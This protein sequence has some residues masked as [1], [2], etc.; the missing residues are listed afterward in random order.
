MR[1][2][3]AELKVGVSN[4]TSAFCHSVLRLEPYT[5]CYFSCTY[6]YAR[7]Y[8]EQGPPEPK[9][10][11]I[12]ALRKLWPKL[13]ASPELRLVPFRLSTLADPLQPAEAKEKL[14][15][16]ILRL[17][18]EFDVPVVLNTKSV[19][20]TRG[21]WLSA[22]EELASEGLV[23]LQVSISALSPA[24]SYTHLTLPTTERV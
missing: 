18:G 1:V 21:P 4:H 8:R 13:A 7:W 19:L 24:V 2:L 14:A 22:L 10:W 17:A 12:K 6:C 3:E 15:L 9:P 16:S 11:L 23:L 20:F 5:A